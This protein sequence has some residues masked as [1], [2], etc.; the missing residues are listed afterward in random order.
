MANDFVAP[1]RAEVLRSKDFIGRDVLDTTGEKVGSVG[2][3]L[4][5]GR[6]GKP[7]FLDLDFGMLRRQHVLLPVSEIEWGDDAF[8]LSRWTKDQ[9]RSLPPYQTDKPLTRD[10]LD[11]LERTFPQFYGSED[12]IRT[13]TRQSDAPQI[14]PLKEAKDFKL[15][16]G[17]TD[18][19]GWNVFG[20]DGERVGEVSEMLVDP[21]AMKVRF[22]DVDVLDDLFTLSDDRHVLIPTENVELRERGEDV[23]IQG[24]RA[25]EVAH[26]LPAYTGGPVHPATERAVRETFAPRERATEPVEREATTIRIE[27]NE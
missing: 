11:E 20:S 27:S 26:R 16:K 6:S 7:R 1:A 24:L 14:V 5:D 21:V 22:L 2:D 8:V 17:A 13:A 19:R 12:A 4:L 9:V 15:S 10:A 25:D 23:W 18:L 3:L